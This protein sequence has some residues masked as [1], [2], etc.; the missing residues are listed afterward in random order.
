MPEVIQT[1]AEF[2]EKLAALGMPV[3][4]FLALVGSFFGV[5]EWGKTARAN[6]AKAE[7]RE[8]ALIEKHETEIAELRA[9]FVSRETHLLSRNDW[10]LEKM[11]EASQVVEKSARAVARRG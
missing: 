7:Q 8:V 9:S 5:W 1:W 6:L 3:F 11:L 2:Y 10:L 4:M